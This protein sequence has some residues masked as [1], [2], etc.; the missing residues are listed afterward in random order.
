M[1]PIDSDR[2]REVSSERQANI[3]NEKYSF[4]HLKGLSSVLIG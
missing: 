3:E 2:Q 1:G 4:S